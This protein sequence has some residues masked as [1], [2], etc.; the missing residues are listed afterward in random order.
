MINTRIMLTAIAAVLP[1]A[2]CTVKEER[3]QCPC[4]LDVNLENRASIHPEAGVQDMTVALWD[5]SYIGSSGVTA[6]EAER[7]PVHEETVPRGDVTVSVISGLDGMSFDRGAV[8][9]PKG[10]QA[11]RVYAFT[12]TADCSGE[13]TMVDAVLHRQF[14][15]ITL[16]MLC[17]EGEMYTFIPRITG[18][19]AGFNARDLSPLEGVF[20]FKP[21]GQGTQGN[22]FTVLVPRQGDFSLSLDLMDSR[23]RVDGTVAIGEIIEGSGYDWEAE[24][25]EDIHLVI[26]HARIVVGIDIR[27]WSE[28]EREFHLHE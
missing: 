4:W 27:P 23:G 12:A 25:L 22:I 16:E 11:D 3:T 21:E 8:Y 10:C 13:T 5:F 24:D 9:V 19:W 20:E 1:L 18:R 17:N 14:A 15:A 7:V 2:S 28:D 26:D 6:R